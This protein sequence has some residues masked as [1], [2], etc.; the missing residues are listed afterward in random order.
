MAITQHH[1]LCQ[2]RTAIKEMKLTQE[3]ARV[4]HDPLF[5]VFLGLS[6][7]CNNM[8]RGRLIQ[9][10]ECYSAVPCLCELLAVLWVNQKVMP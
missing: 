5:L 7:A 9:T 8:D 1:L 6:K 2:I 3:L 4:N 10:L